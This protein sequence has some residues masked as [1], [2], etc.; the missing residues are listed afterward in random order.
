M[1]LLHTIA[2]AAPVF[3]CQIVE[4][5][6]ITGKDLAAANPIF[7]KLDPAM[8]IGPAPL[9]GVRRVWHAEESVRL[10]RQNGIAADAPFGEL[11]FERATG[12]LTTESLLPILQTALAI[13]AQIEIVDFSRYAVARGRI[14]FTRDG[15]T[16]AGL[17]RGRVTYAEGRSAAIWAKVRVTVEQT[18]VEAVEPLAPGKIVD[19]AQLAIRKGRRFPFGTAPIDSVELVAGRKL[20]RAIRP[21]EP[22]F[23]SM[24]IAPFEIERGDKVTVAVSS[25]GATLGFDA[26]AETAGRVG[27]SVLIKT[28]ENGHRFQARVEGKGK[29]SITK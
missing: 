28:P 6:R 5:D 19:A 12:Q 27:G 21:G 7:A 1:R 16:P 29:V 13:D 20:A 18:W 17:W 24:L 9:A 22:I 15:L 23:A 8:V 11:C 26:I 25:G 4:G 3:A 10:A 2:L 14:E